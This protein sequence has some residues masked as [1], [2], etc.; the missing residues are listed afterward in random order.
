VNSIIW[1]NTPDQINDP[2]DQVAVNYSD[3]DPTGAWTGVGT[4]NIS[5]DPLSCDPT[6]PD[7]DLRLPTVRSATA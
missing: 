1:G 2:N 3:I 6:D 5:A 7:W 4:G